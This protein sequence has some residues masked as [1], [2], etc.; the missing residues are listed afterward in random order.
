[1]SH[2]EKLPPQ[3]ESLSYC[4]WAFDTNYRNIDSNEFPPTLRIL[5]I[6]QS[7]ELKRKMPYNIDHLENLKYLVVVDFNLSK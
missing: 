6:H 1:M 5:R 4:A 2:V 3:L 7:R